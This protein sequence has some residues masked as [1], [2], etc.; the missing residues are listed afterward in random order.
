MGDLLTALGALFTKDDA[1]ILCVQYPLHSTTG[2]FGVILDG[3]MEHSP[4]DMRIEKTTLDIQAFAEP[5]AGDWAW[6]V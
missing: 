3:R 1:L 5:G 6:C 2:I 4:V